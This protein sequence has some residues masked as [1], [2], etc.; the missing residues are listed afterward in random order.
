MAGAPSAARGGRDYLL[1]ALAALLPYLNALANGFV[2]DD[3]GQI[4]LNEAVGSFDL[5]SLF[6][7]DYWA[8][9]EGRQSGLYRP[10]TSLSFSL[11]YRLW[12]ETPALFHLTG[13]IAG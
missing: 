6:T 1:V 5:R 13:L 7:S 11:E 2:L 8:G 4:L 3:V 10:L 12:G 9:F